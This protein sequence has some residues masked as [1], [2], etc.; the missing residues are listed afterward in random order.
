MI[1]KKF[2]I[3]SIEADKP[4]YNG[5]IYPR[6]VMEKAVSEYNEIIKK[7]KC[8]VLLGSS[9]NHDI[10]LHKIA[11]KVTSCALIDNKITIEATLLNTP[12]GKS[13]EK[14]LR[15]DVDVIPNMNCKINNDGVV[16][17]DN[18]SSFSIV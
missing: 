15:F 12:A 6:E 8:F 17:I 11:M 3:N 13:L 2:I 4:T 7:D 14:C 1:T 9:N 5:R 18:I 16:S 10:E